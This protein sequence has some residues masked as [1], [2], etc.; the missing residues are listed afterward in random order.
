LKQIEEA[1][2]AW[3]LPAMGTGGISF[4]HLLSEFTQVF[5]Q[6]IAFTGQWP[7]YAAGFENEFEVQEVGATRHIELVKTANGYSV[8]FS[9]AS[10]QII[11]KL[12]Q[13]RPHVVFANAFSIW[14]VFALAFKAIGGW[15]VIITYEGGSPTYES[16]KRSI[17]LLARQAM[18]KFADAFVV[19]SQT[20]EAYFIDILGVSADRILTRP[21][22]VPS[23]KAL[24]Q[25]SVDTLPKFSPDAKSPVFLYAGQII[26]RKGLK[27][28]L[29]A[30]KLLKQQG[31]QDYTVRIVGD[32]EQRSELETFVEDCDLVNQV[33]W[34]GKVEYRCLGAYFQSADI[35]VF[36][37]YEDIWGMV[38]P[39]AM[40]FG[41][42]VI[43]SEK[44]GAVEMVRPENGFVFNPE[45][46][47]ELAT[48][49]RHFLDDP[50]LIA[51]MGETAKQMML[52]H[53]P[54]QAI[55]PF[56]QAVEKVLSNGL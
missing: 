14:T 44:A 42:P 29:E 34:L 22:L 6:T 33:E 4:Q 13:F 27:V 9:Y 48:C 25:C 38:I 1:R 5:Q 20:G 7:G 43:C 31:Y 2:I 24:L 49:I 52:C 50:T 35:F 11:Q 36:P 40:A 23:V 18:V 26:P 51:K 12:F 16:P 32:G 3:L 15:K 54:E 17:R 53:T 19:N 45:S 37:T 39:E 21:F 8:G 30:C 46:V 28:L 10:P 47:D 56:V 55:Q 41:K